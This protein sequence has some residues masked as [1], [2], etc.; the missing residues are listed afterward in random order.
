[1]TSGLSTPNNETELAKPYPVELL[2]DQLHDGLEAQLLTLPLGKDRQHLLRL[3]L[4]HGQEP[5]P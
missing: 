2:K 3:L 4:S 1:M 5:R